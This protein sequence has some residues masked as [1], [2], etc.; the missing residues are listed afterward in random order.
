MRKK[1]ILNKFCWNCIIL[2]LSFISLTYFLK[3]ETLAFTLEE[4]INTALENNQ[5]IKTAYLNTQ[6]ASLA[7][8]EAFGYALPS[9]DFSA[10]YYHFL[11]KSK[12][13]FPDFEALLTNAT[14]SILFNENVIP[15]DPQKFKPINTVLQSFVQTNNYEAKAQITQ[16]LFNSAVFEGIGASKVYLELSKQQLRASISK[17]ILEVKKAYYGVLLLQELLEIME[18]SLKN[19]EDN[20]ANLRAIYNQGIVS[21]YDLLQAEVRVENIRPSVLQLR[22][23]LQNAKNGLKLIMGIEQDKDIQ[24]K[25]ELIYEKDKTPSYDDLIKVAYE[26]N[27][28]ILILEQKKELDKAVVAVERG[29]YYPTLAA[30]GNYSFSGSADNLKFQNYSSAIV[31]LSF[32]INLFKGNQTNNR[33]QQAKIGIYQTENQI[34][35]LKDYLS[36]QIKSK[37]MDMERVESNIIAQQRNVQLAQKA[38]DISLVKYREGTGTQLDIQN[39]DIALRQAKTNLMQSTYDYLIAKFELEYLVGQFDPKYINKFNLRK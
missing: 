13:P 32:S 23:S 37:L 12:M 21:E 10:N 24:V 39:S 31:G 14:Y 6:K 8:D 38:Y 9:V 16:I 19:A 15:Y 26:Q 36:M 2:F 1:N 4:A 28:D 34:N 18:A 17:T 7:V 22:N 29:G 11:Q 27:A 25:G 3:A 5:D 30:F 20:L 35:Q 33:V